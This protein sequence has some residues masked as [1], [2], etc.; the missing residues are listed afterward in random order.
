MQALNNDK[1]SIFSGINLTA[2]EE[3]GLKGICDFVLSR[4]TEVEMIEY[5]LFTLIEAKYNAVEGAYG[6]CIAQM[7]GCKTLNEQKQQPIPII[8]GCIT[9]GNLWKFLKL[10]DNHIWIDSPQYFMD[11]ADMTR[12]GKILGILQQIIEEEVV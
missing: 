2:N 8:Y 12:L 10:E 9:T 11:G 5:P 7:L 1:F 4:A 3:K 6:Q